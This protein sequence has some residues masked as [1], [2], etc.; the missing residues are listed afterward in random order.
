MVESVEERQ[1]RLLPS[2]DEKKKPLTPSAG[3]KWFGM[4]AP[5]NRLRSNMYI[6]P[7]TYTFKYI[8]YGLTKW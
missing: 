4:K 6:S 5:G 1:K 3:D 8:L 7:C 2:R